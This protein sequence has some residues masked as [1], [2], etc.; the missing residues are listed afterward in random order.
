[1][2][3]SRLSGSTYTETFRLRQVAGAFAAVTTSFD[4]QYTSGESTSVINLRSG[5]DREIASLQHDVGTQAAET[6]GRRVAAIYVTSG[7]RGAASVIESESGDVQIVAFGA[8]GAPQPVDRGTTADI[9]AES[10]TL[11]GATLSWTHAGAVRT[12]QLPKP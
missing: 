4:D 1:M 12:A 5:K 7:G 2:I 3:A 11:A 9:P 8:H 6:D 10:L